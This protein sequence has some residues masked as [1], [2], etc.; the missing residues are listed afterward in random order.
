MAES[1]TKSIFDAPS[2]DT[3]EA[4]FDAKAEAEVDAGEG[5]PH[6]QVRAWLRKLGKG[7]KVVPPTV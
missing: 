1:D 4:R 6:E 5:I 3:E 7:E 2:D